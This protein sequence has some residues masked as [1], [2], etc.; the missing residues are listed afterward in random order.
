M[1][2]DATTLFEGTQGWAEETALLV[3]EALQGQARNFLVGRG[4]DQ[5]IEQLK[6]AVAAAEAQ[7]AGARQTWEETRLA[8]A[9]LESGQTG[10]TSSS[11]WTKAALV[12]GGGFVVS[13]VLL[14]VYLPIGLL[15]L[16][17]SLILGII[18]A[19][20]ASSAGS[21][22]AA[23][24]T[25]TKSAFSNAA[26][27]G[28]EAEAHLNNLRNRY[29]QLQSESNRAVFQKDLVAVGRVQ[30]P[31]LQTSVAGYSVL[32]DGSGL[33][34]N[35][36]LEIMA[37]GVDSEMLQKLSVAVENI[38]GLP[39][40]L[41]P[42]ENDCG[43]IELLQGEEAALV[44]EMDS[45]QSSLASCKVNPVQVPLVPQT[46]P[47]AKLAATVGTTQQPSGLVLKKSSPE[48]NNALVSLEKY[49]S[50]MRKQGHHMEDALQ[51][52]RDAV[53]AV[54]A[55]T[56]QSR[57]SALDAAHSGFLEVSARS[58]LA[59][60]TCYCPKCNRIPQYVFGHLGVDLE[61]AHRMSP[62]DLVNCLQ[63]DESARTR[64]AKDDTLLTALSQSWASLS[65]IE[66]TLTGLESALKESGDAIGA[67]LRE[68]HA[69]EARLRALRAHHT[70]TL[71]H[72][73]ST[74]RV[75]L[76]G[77]PHPVLSL[78]RQ[79]RLLLNP[80][81]GTW[82]CTV[83]ETEFSDGELVRM[84]RM[85]RIK[86]ELLM[87]MWNQL[88]I[89]K[90]NLRKS[91]LFRTNEQIARLTEKETVAL[92]EVSEQYRADMRPVRE[93]LVIATTEG[94][95]KR[96]QLHAAVTSLVALGVMPEERGAQTLARIQAMTGDK[97]D[98]N[99]KRAEAKETLLNQEPQAQ[100][101]RRP[102]AVDPVDVLL[103]PEALFQEAEVVRPNL[104]LRLPEPT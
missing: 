34:K 61:N 75:I 67:D 57:Q 14:A 8:V 71:D 22:Y 33:Q 51:Q 74:L 54:L 66:T 30:I 56:Q 59:H 62:R 31:L 104:A 19:V 73:R 92:R 4:A 53:D 35:E 15:G 32:L 26:Q 24:L 9:N 25:Q 45:L 17:A 82:S 40:L 60:V 83:C 102:T 28:S 43:S 29:A 13:L 12:G 49:T 91:E 87:P 37:S 101:L 100:M 103:S 7:L 18:F 48:L 94:T 89:E 50:S 38:S 44:A 46:A 1:A 2:Q 42:A 23:Q 47:L 16:M 78:S 76:T 84:G 69:L 36:V 6:V 64:L 3:Y 52:T 85:L 95:H 77:S 99:R 98:E 65:E 81:A 11:L 5:E 21:K 86:D 97:L 41:S 55:S 70:S 10:N 63:E 27:R 93:N 90:D 58:Y 79:A 39:M 20:Q 72:F 96:D 68:I 80:D 88:W